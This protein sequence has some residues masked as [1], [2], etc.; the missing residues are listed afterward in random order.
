MKKHIKLISILAVT[1]V[2]LTLVICLHACSFTKDD[3]P[4]KAPV[5]VN[6]EESTKEDNSS[7]YE[8]PTYQSP[9]NDEEKTTKEEEMTTDEVTTE[10][11]PEKSLSYSSNGNGTCS[12]T[13]IGN[14][15]DSCIIIPERSPDGDVVTGI[16]D[17]AFY[18][19]KNV[20]AIQIPSTVTH[21]GQMAFGGCTSLIYISVNSNN[22]SFVDKNGVLYTAD[23]EKLIHYPALKGDSTLTLPKTIISIS[24]MAF[25]NCNSLEYINFEGN[26]SDWAK[27]RIGEYNYG[28][29][30]V[31]V[32]CADSK[33]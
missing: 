23:M 24:D 19:N 20:N 15:T 28:L 30:A 27:I 29:F 2:S 25:Y 11:I 31:S 3:T 18:E 6:P 1:A 33:K 7:I 16:I 22:R 12:V 4:T 26:M 5:E 8:P 10:K 13:G 32:S 9:S 21:I 17:K 14:I